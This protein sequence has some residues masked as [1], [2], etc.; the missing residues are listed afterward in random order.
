[1][2]RVLGTFD[3]AKMGGTVQ[4]TED[5]NVLVNGQKGEEMTPGQ[6]RALYGLVVASIIVALLLVVTCLVQTGFVH[7]GAMYAF[8]AVAFVFLGL[9]IYTIGKRAAKLFAAICAAALVFATA[10]FALV[11]YLN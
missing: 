10:M 8:V 4:V 11:A 5:G 1:M 9:F 3:V 6:I 2:S 7:F